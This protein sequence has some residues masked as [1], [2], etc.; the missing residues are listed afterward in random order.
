MLPVAVAHSPSSGVAIRYVLPVLW[1]TSRLPITVTLPQ[2]PRCSA[3]H[4]LTPT[5]AAL[6]YRL[7]PVLYGG[8]G[9]VEMR[10]AAPSR[11]ADDV[12][13]S[14]RPRDIQSETPLYDVVAA[15]CCSE[16][17]RRLTI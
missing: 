6:R 12:T 2:Q 16:D 11:R 4:G 9:K 13:H 1:M 8:G 17:T 5:T 14:C 15:A 3:V 7:I 10:R